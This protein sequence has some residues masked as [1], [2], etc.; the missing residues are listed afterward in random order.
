[1]VVMIDATAVGAKGGRFTRQAVVR[2]R[3]EAAL[4]QSPYQVL[5]WGT[6]SE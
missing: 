2:L 6:P 1:M 3:A 5:T 4:D